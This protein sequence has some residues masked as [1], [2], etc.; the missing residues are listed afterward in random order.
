MLPLELIAKLQP[1]VALVRCMS[2]AGPA[3]NKPVSHSALPAA[4]AKSRTAIKGT[5]P[6]GTLKNSASTSGYSDAPAQ[7]LQEVS[8]EKERG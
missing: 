3:P 2:H 6:K 5:S 7:A 4:P 1:T 8:R